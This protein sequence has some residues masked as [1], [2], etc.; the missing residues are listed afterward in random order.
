M[1]LIRGSDGGGEVS[2]GKV[3]LN[4]TEVAA[5]GGSSSLIMVAHAGCGAGAV[6]DEALSYGSWNLPG[7]LA[8]AV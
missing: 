7:E 5:S 8:G 1:R 2:I 3:V 6:A 4:A